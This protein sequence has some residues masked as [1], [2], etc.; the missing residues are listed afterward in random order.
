MFGTS[1]TGSTRDNLNHSKLIILW[2]WNPADTRFGPDTN[3]HLLQAKKAGA[4]IIV[5][6]PRESASFQAFADEWIP[7]KPGTDAVMWWS[8]LTK[9]AGSSRKPK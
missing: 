9:E 3:P 6:D 7:V 4:R 5:V 2:G 8:F 1:L